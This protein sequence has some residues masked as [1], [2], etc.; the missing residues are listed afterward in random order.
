M[1]SGGSW[2]RRGLKDGIPIALGYFTVAVSLGIAARNAGITA[3]EG[4]IMSLTNMTSAGEFA[5]MTVIAAGS[6]YLVM[7]MLQLVINARYLLMSCSLS[8]RLDERL[9][10]PKRFLLG[11]TITDEIFGISIRVE[12]ERLDPMY[13]L[14]AFCVACP[15]WTLGT[16]CG[17][18]MGNILPERVV[19]ALSVALFG[20]LIAVF[21]PPTKKDKVVA[22]A[23]A[24]SMI[25][26]YLFTK[27]PLF[28]RISGG[29][30]LILLTVLIAGAAAVLFPVKEEG[31]D[32]S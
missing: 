7:A 28:S 27:L 9:S 1:D 11:L 26:S 22:G 21:V 29:V 20:M 5:G 24:L 4:G 10:I 31:K 2:F 12:G 3:I 23:V 13:S 25:L 15:G 19:T 14:G 16:V 17:A 32:E 6:S 8:Q 18:V 30:K